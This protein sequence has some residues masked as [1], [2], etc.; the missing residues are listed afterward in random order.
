MNIPSAFLDR[1]RK[2]LSE[3]DV[4]RLVDGIQSRRVT[5]FRSNGLLSGAQEAFD[6]LAAK[7]VPFHR[8]PWDPHAAWVSADDR[9]ALLD[10]AVARAGRLYVQSLSSQLPVHILDPQPGEEVLDLAAAPGSKTL[11]LAVRVPGA[12]IAAVEVV[13]KR[14][15]KL[16]DNLKMHGADGVRVY[17][18]D[19]TK[20]WRYRPDHFDRVLI[21]APCSSEGRFQA[22]DPDS[23]AY[24][25]PRKVK[26]MVRKQRRLLFSALRAVRPGGVVVYSTCALS[27]EENE[28]VIQ[29][30]LD[31]FEGQ[32]TIEPIAWPPD[33]PERIPALTSWKKTEFDP[34][35]AGCLRILPSERMEGFFVC[36]LR[37]TD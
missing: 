37:R 9:Q 5:A 15:Y 27:P 11:Q 12:Q 18:Q 23:M 32:V 3:Q 1:C 10:S 30:Q 13:K 36:R 28:G 6:E 2:F 25:S 26:E 29:S 8:V 14:M 16:K 35:M 20:V 31:A 24:W 33:L 21:D 4:D 22:D 19:G 7:G 34:G 17:L